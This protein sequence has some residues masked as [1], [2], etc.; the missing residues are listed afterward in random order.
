VYYILK[1][2]GCKESVLYSALLNRTVAAKGDEVKTPLTVDQAYQ[3]RDA[4]AKAIYDRMF[5][6]LVN[7]INSSLMSQVSVSYESGQCLL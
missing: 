6:W 7:Q 5:T 1:L 4:L 3:A 2:L